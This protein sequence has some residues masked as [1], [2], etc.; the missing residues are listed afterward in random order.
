MTNGVFLS[1]PTTYVIWGEVIFSQESTLDHEPHGPTSPPSGGWPILTLPRKVHQKE[2]Q[3]DLTVHVSYGQRQITAYCIDT[4][5]LAQ[6]VPDLYSH[7]SQ[8]FHHIDVNHSYFGIIR[9]FFSGITHKKIRKFSSSKIAAYVRYS[10]VLVWCFP[11]WI[12]LAFLVKLSHLSSVLAIFIQLQKSMGGWTNRGK[13][14][15]P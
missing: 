11:D 15:D 5:S 2:F 8:S 14:K 1:L 13:V 12:S 3:P 10:G 7:K 6:Q 9:T 4:C